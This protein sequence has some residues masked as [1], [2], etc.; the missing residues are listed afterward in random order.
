MKKLF[1][2]FTFYYPKTPYVL[3]YMLQQ[4]E[5]EGG[6][7]LSWAN[8]LPDYRRVM[9]RK[10]LVMTRMAQL[11]LL[12]SYG[13]VLA[14][15]AGLIWLVKEMQIIIAALLLGWGPLL[16]VC[17]LAAVCALGK[18]LLS[19]KRKKILKQASEKMATHPGIKIAVLGSFGKT[20][21]KEMLATVLSEGKK[22][23]YTPGNM[24]VDISH[25]R[26]IMKRIQGDED[27]VIFEFGEFRPGDIA[28][29]AKLTHPNLAIVTGYAPNHLDSYK[30]AENLKKDLVS[31]EQFVKPEDIY[32]SE[33]AAHNLTFS[34][35]KVKTYG[36]EHIAGWKI[37]G[38]SSGFDGTKLTIKKD[39]HS[40]S[41]QSQLLGKHLAPLIGLVAVLA[42]QL[43]MKE[44]EIK[45]GVAK[46]VP[47]EH[48]LQPVLTSGAWVIDDTYNGSIEGMRVG[49]ALLAELPAERK[50]Y[51][52]PGLV[53]QGKETEK[54]HTELGALITHAAPDQVVLMKNSVSNIIEKSLMENGFA[55]KLRIV[56]EPLEFYTNLQYEL[57]AGDV[58]LMQNDWTDN[59]A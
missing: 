22:V 39:K 36:Q 12:L 1:N 51:V 34:S 11:L 29:F 4:V 52:T 16:L 10:K 13:A 48:R 45:A 25:A 47:Y 19:T 14:W 50:I 58:V 49:L 8:R 41:L 46:T 43:G 54:V 20:T 56:E 18:I 21:A 3:V 26:W 55:G 33:Q 38:V 44:E 17:F 57:A 28:A 5:Y 24:N 2:F 27:V 23:A 35:G 53:E 42:R 31:I 9:R 59:Y 7:F 40:L 32:I 30:S 37:S 6:Q 15:V